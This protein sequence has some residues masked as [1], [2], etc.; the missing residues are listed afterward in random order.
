MEDV[1]GE[2][3]IAYDTTLISFFLRCDLKDAV[4]FEYGASFSIVKKPVTGSRQD[5]AEQD[6]AGTS[7]TSENDRTSENENNDKEINK[8]EWSTTGST[9]SAEALLGTSQQPAN[10]RNR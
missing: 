6:V 8:T 1:L 5:G 3:L 2:A 4:A 10:Q 9:K 7:R